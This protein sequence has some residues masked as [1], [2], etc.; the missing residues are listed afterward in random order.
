MKL[1]AKPT[2]QGCGM[3]VFTTAQIVLSL[4]SAELRVCKQ[5]VGSAVDKDR[6]AVGTLLS[7]GDAEGTN[8]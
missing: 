7:G 1:A 8:C 6:I 5:G 3:R 4:V 2:D